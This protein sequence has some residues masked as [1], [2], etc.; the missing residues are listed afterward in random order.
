MPGA[1]AA[2][3]GLLG[4]TAVWVVCN[5]RC[6]PRA[7]ATR[8]RDQRGPRRRAATALLHALIPVAAGTDLGGAAVGAAV[9]LAFQAQRFGPSPWRWA[10]LAA[11]VP[12]PWLGY[13]FIGHE[14]ATNPEWAAVIQRAAYRPTRTR[15]SERPFRTPS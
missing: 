15:R 8:M 5:D 7:V 11:L 1:W 2:I 9:G 6:L 12:L 4:A 14:M 3:Y 10:A 13:T